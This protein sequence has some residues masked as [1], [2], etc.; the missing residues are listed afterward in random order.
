MK[1]YQPRWA[2]LAAA[3][4]LVPASGCTLE[5]RYELSCFVQNAADGKPLSG[6]LALLDTDGRADDLTKGRTGARPTDAEGRLTH[7]FILISQPGTKRWYLKLE[8]D[9]FE[10]LVIDI[11]PAA[12]LASGHKNPQSVVGQMRPK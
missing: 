2:L 4:F 10:P 12:P 11:T 5:Y 1:F 3:A 8:K 6:V 7:E 9:G